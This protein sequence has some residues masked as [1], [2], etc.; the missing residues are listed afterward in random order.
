MKSCQ[1]SCQIGHLAFSGL[2]RI[3]GNRHDDVRAILLRCA[4]DQLF[5]LMWRSADAGNIQNEISPR[6]CHATT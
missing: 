6:S 5:N 2:T 3:L 4:D 1:L